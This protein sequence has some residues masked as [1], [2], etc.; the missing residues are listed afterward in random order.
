M[1]IASRLLL[2][3]STVALFA[4]G[5]EVAIRR[6]DGFELTAAQLRPKRQAPSAAVPARPDV[7]T[8]VA[9]LPVADGVRRE[10][11]DLSPDPLPRPPLTPELAAVM[12]QTTTPEIFK[13]WNTRLIQERLCAGDALFDAFP[14]F[15]FSFEPADGSPHPPYRYLPGVATP[16]GLVTNSFG[17]RG[18]EITS[19]KPPRTLRIAFVGASTTVGPHGQPFSYPELIERW[20]N[21][22]GSRAVPG[23]RIET[24]NAGR[25]GISARDIAAVVRD[26]VVPLEPDVI[27]YLEG[28]NQFTARALAVSTG[29]PIVVPSTLRPR[30]VPGAA[31]FD[32]ARRVDVLF[33][34]FG[35]GSGAEPVKQAHRLQWPSSVS[36]DHPDPD[37][38]DLPLNLTDIVR[39]LD[40][41]RTS[42]K[43]AGATLVLSSF[44]WMVKN[45]LV[46]DRAD[47]G[48]YYDAINLNY[49]PL[50]YA[51]L[52]RLADFQNR[53][54]RAYAESR[55]IPFVDPAAV[56]PL[57]VSLFSDPVHTTADG[58]RLR[59]WV[60][61]QLL[62][63]IVREQL[64]SR[65]LSAP[66]RSPG[67]RLRSPTAA[68]SRTELRCT[69]FS[70]HMPIA[71]ALSVQ[72][73]AAVAG[74]AVT[75]DGVKHVVTSGVRY[76]YAAEAQLADTARSAGP[77]VI[78]VRVHVTSGSVAI[79]LLARD[80]STFLVSR[81]L[82]TSAKAVDVYM[83]VS[84]LA[85]AASVVISN[86]V[87]TPGQR[88]VV[89]VEDLAVL[90]P[91][92]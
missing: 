47:H 51:E 10:W 57:D 79:G 73:L 15:A 1:N 40:D 59:A 64:A 17:F 49:W 68:L 35:F 28:S 55:R 18:R 27:V 31:T 77:G 39:A 23:I 75:G 6:L 86:G 87:G 63:P 82:D 66:D 38:A 90:V 81:W 42:A 32:V 72:A 65:R 48:Y 60:M 41:I 24:I 91:G 8:Y 46:V 71:G 30:A 88:S 19:D 45:G 52:R 76:S 25:E 3:G 58:D 69:D 44:I 12:K 4:A 22:W 2:G 92:Y 14:G 21:E 5:L 80:R 29:G 83:P 67:P 36:E 84:S 85:D 7:R 13:L 11:F 34:R 33:Q 20:L 56:F 62:V 50:T 26:E 78:R 43:A 53:V 37:G 54:F 70:R 16:S 61:L 9:A 89:D 74:A